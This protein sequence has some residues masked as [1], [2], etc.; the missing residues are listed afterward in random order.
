[1][2]DGGDYKVGVLIAA[3]CRQPSPYPR[4]GPVKIED[5]VGKGL[6]NGLCPIRK[7]GGKDR[8]DPALTVNAPFDL[9]QRHNCQMQRCILDLPAPRNQ[10]RNTLWPAQKRKDVCI[11]DSDQNPMSRLAVF[12][13]SAV[14]QSSSPCGIANR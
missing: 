2:G 7:R 9:A 12:G 5:A 13:R 11:Q 10:L 6:V 14:S 3:L 8:I 4:S 1:M